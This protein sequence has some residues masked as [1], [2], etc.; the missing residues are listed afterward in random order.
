MVCSLKHGVEQ[1]T[2]LAMGNERAISVDYNIVMAL[3]EIM[4]RTLILTEEGC[5]VHVA[6]V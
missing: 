2:I 1:L 3:N 5:P 6:P 4:T